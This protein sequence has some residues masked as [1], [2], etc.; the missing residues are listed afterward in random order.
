VIPV[1]CS[2][3]DPKDFNVSVP[4]RATAMTGSSELPFGKVIL[5][6][7]MVDRAD[8][9]DRV[10]WSV[11]DDMSCTATGERPKTRAE[12]ARESRRYQMK[13]GGWGNCDGG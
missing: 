8:R 7:E 4:K 2:S 13:A 11:L 3:E 12:P 5:S 9:I 10:Q 6:E 1:I